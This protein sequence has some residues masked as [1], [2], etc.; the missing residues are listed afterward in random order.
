ME[1]KMKKNEAV[2][3]FFGETEYPLYLSNIKRKNGEIV[4]GWVENGHWDYLV[5]NGKVY[6]GS[7][8]EE[9]YIQDL[10]E[11]ITEIDV[12]DFDG[13]YNDVIWQARQLIPTN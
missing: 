6:C 3:L 5:R 1:M 4:S 13:H 11:K 7:R 12:T 9:D 2:V 10:P 8:N